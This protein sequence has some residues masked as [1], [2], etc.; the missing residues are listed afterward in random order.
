MRRFHVRRGLLGRGSV[1]A[2]SWLG[3]SRSPQRTSI[4]LAR[5]CKTLFESRRTRLDRE[6]TAPNCRLHPRTHQRSARY[7]AAYPVIVCPAH[8]ERDGVAQVFHVIL[9]TPRGS[10]VR[11]IGHATGSGDALLI[12]L[13]FGDLCLQSLGKISVCVSELFQY[14]NRFTTVLAGFF[15]TPMPWRRL[16]VRDPV[17]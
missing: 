2:R 5:V 14:Q 9:Q 13:V 17:R 7:Y 15:L 16:Q 12:L 4:R 6:G 1:V 10:T 8:L 3:R 11:I